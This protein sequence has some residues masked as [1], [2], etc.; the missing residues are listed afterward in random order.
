M[1]GRGSTSIPILVL[2]SLCA[3]M[4]IN[5]YTAFEQNLLLPRWLYFLL[6]I[7]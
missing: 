2:W 5:P 3:D 4:G 1:N 7:A 6:G